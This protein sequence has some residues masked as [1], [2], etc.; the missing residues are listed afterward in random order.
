MS[1]TASQPSQDAS[2]PL[3][4]H[5]TDIQRLVGQPVGECVRSSCLKAANPANAVQWQ[6]SEQSCSLPCLSQG[7]TH[8]LKHQE[9]QGINWV[10]RELCW[11]LSYS[12]ATHSLMLHCLISSHCWQD[13]TSCCRKMEP[14][15]LLLDAWIGWSHQELPAEPRSPHT[16][17]CMA[18]LKK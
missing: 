4:P 18:H 9:H 17:I 3:N 10:L 16:Q 6:S 14:D 7:S 13:K 2:E 12:C 5:L 8:S 11:S 15:A 1:Q